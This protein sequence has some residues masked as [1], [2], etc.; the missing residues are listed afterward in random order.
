MEDDPGW[1]W[2]RRKVSGS[3]LGDS[4][5]PPDGR[6]PP[7]PGA[8]LMA[9]RVIFSAFVTGVVL[10]GI[11]TVVAV[12]GQKTK[13]AAQ[14]L[15]FPLIVLGISAVM[16]LVALKIKIKLDC[17]SEES[18]SSTYR[19]RF[20][21]RAAIAEGAALLGIVG[22]LAAAQWWM[23]PVVMII[24]AVGFA[25][26]APTTGSIRREQERLQAAGCQYSLMAALNGSPVGR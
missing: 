10:F 11:V 21:I 13:P 8:A 9:I 3:P 19:G 4:T 5:D 14:S 26:T 20:V 25:S 17:S 12:S 1:P 23:V 2:A 6:R 24:G 16:V 18:L 7:V 22:F 15:A